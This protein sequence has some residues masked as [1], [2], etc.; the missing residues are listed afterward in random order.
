MAAILPVTKTYDQCS[1]AERLAYFDA[2]LA[3]WDV[4]NTAQRKFDT[5]VQ[6]AT[7]IDDVSG[8]KADSLEALRDLELLDNKYRAFKS[9]QTGIIPP[10]D[11]A[12]VDRIQKTSAQ[13]AQIVAAG[14]TAQTILTLMLQGKAEFDA[15]SA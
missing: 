13:L 15:L 8:Y 1:D 6:I 14:D 3:A 2:Y 11:Q 9:G 10:P 4:V 7:A 5:L 12:V